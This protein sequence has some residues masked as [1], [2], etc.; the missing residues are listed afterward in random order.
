M[1][2][3]NLNAEASVNDKIKNAL[4]TYT[5]LVRENFKKTFVTLQGGKV[6]STNDFSNTYK[7]KLDSI[8]AGAEK[9][10]LNG[11]TF[12]GAE[13][14]FDT[15]TKVASVTITGG[16]N[17]VVNNH[18]IKSASITGADISF[19]SDSAIISITGGE[20]EN[21]FVIN[22][23]TIKSA[24]ITGADISFESDSAIISIT[25]GDVENNFV[26]NNHT[27]KSASITGA[28]ISFE[29][30][31]AIISITGGEAENN[32]VINNHTV[33][34]ASITGAD[35]S[36]ESD[37]AIIS[38]TGGGM[39][40]FTVNGAAVSA[41]SVTG[42]A[43]VTSESDTA[44]VSIPGGMEKV[45]VVGGALQA[46]VDN[47]TLFLLGSNATVQKADANLILSPANI[48]LNA[49]EPATIS[50]THSGNG[51][52]QIIS[53]RFVQSEQINAT[54]F[55]ISPKYAGQGN[56]GFWLSETE[57]YY[58]AAA[59]VSITAQD[60]NAMPVLMHFDDA[61][62]PF[63]NEGFAEVIETKTENAAI[64]ADYGKFGSGISVSGATY[65]T[66]LLPLGG[67]D[68]SVSLWAKSNL[69]FYLSKNMGNAIT[70]GI[71][72]NTAALSVTANGNSLIQSNTYLLN[73]EMQ[74]VAMVYRHDLGKLRLFQNGV[75]TGEADI[76][77]DRVDINFVS[78]YFGNL[79][80]IADELLILDGVAQYW[81]NFTPPTEPF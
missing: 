35:I 48:T 25:G 60:D 69:G 23:H 44:I 16:N 22:N 46:S 59:N 12:K 53:D 52:V 79:K 34:S 62:Q 17:F 32:F 63:L 71:M 9:N 43:S 66:T 30:D 36:F 5:P 77:F 26:I 27:I 13:Y 58:G 65:F 39:E 33:K 42:A 4:N 72:A 78:L 15:A 10:L 50:A 21:N 11:V 74:H 24:S 54:D 64:G 49:F 47:K 14:D 76:T 19:E 7:N 75:K 68:F 57:N 18:T 67:K 28:D 20:A 31:S 61:Q 37:S 81:D 1:A 70:L 55:R 6:L 8:E 38:I 40:N 51:I 41:I 80:T 45:S 56:I 3:K 73:S 29:S 2:D